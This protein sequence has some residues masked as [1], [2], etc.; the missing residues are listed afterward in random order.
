MIRKAKVVQTVSQSDTNQNPNLQEKPDLE[1]VL[2][3]RRQ[4]LQSHFAGTQGIRTDK[5]FDD[6]IA[7]LKVQYTVSKSTED[8]LRAYL[9]P[10]LATRKPP[11]KTSEESG[12]V[13][14]VAVEPSP[15][16]SESLPE[17]SPV[18][19]MPTVFSSSVETDDLGA[20]VGVPP[21]GEHMVHKKKL[22]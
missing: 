8:F 22:R 20:N 6:F 11:K 12:D 2:M 9:T 16:A 3:R 15:K 7:G 17:P 21:A 19:P 4:T 1:H 14:A 5:D 13:V 18:I 10:V